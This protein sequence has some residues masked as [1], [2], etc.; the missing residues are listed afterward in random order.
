MWALGPALAFPYKGVQ[1][2]GPCPFI[3][4]KFR[5]AS[6]DG[7][8]WKLSEACEALRPC[9]ALL[10]PCGATRSL[11]ELPGAS[12]SLFL[13]VQSYGLL[14]LCPPPTTFILP[15]EPIP[16]FCVFQRWVLLAQPRHPCKALRTESHFVYSTNPNARSS[17]THRSYIK[18][19]LIKSQS[20][21]SQSSHSLAFHTRTHTHNLHQ[22]A[23][24][25]HTR[26][27]CTLMHSSRTHRSY[28]NSRSH[29]SRNLRTESHFVYPTNPTSRVWRAV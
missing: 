11:L 28:I 27:L 23:I 20:I 21:T 18:S 19:Q 6:P 5:P 3:A 15:A 13:R 4:K 10:C 12:R 7:L 14:P 17:R 2:N 26:S 25:A 9:R 24:F 8:L 22:V 29:S 1:K 16:H